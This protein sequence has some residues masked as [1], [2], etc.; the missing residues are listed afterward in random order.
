[1]YYVICVFF[2]YTWVYTVQG[3]T[4]KTLIDILTH[5][6]SSQKQAISKAYEETT[7]RVNLCPL[8]DT[9]LMKMILSYD[10][11]LLKLSVLTIDSCKWLE[12]RHQG[13]F[14]K[15]ACCPHQ[16]ACIQWCQMANQSNES[17][18][19]FLIFHFKSWTN[20]SYIEHEYEHILLVV[21]AYIY[22]YIYFFFYRFPNTFMG[23]FFRGQER[24][25]TSWQKYLLHGQIN[26][27]KSCLQHMLRVRWGIYCS[28]KI[29]KLQKFIIAF[30][31]PNRN[32]ENA[33]TELKN[34]SFRGFWQSNPSACWGD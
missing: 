6:S 30:P 27:S 24:T 13:R 19:Y 15:A 29:W 11:H 16:T 5:R 4:E 17:M 3:T 32:K 21:Y 9:H 7:K 2:V 8:T 12:R 34:R 26:R 28:N 14:W 31:L 22:I 10:E 23:C 1:M 18:L 33:D 25:P 20:F